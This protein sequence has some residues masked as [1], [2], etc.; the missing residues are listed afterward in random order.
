MDSD[1]STHLVVRAPFTKMLRVCLKVLEQSTISGRQGPPT[2]IEP[3]QQ[4]GMNLWSRL[5][6]AYRLLL[7]CREPPD[8]PTDHQ[9]GGAQHLHSSSSRRS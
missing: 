2:R 7:I 1:C 9:G 6:T 5:L 8:Q 3:A 4:V